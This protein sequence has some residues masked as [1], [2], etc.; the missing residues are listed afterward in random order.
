VSN[1][2]YPVPARKKFLK[3]KLTEYRLILDLLSQ[4]TLAFP[5]IRFT[6]THN[7]KLVFDFPKTQD[8]TYRMNQVL[9]DSVVSHMIPVSFSD[10]YLQ[11][12]G[13]ITTPQITTKSS[14][15]Q[16]LFIN[17]RLISDRLISL[18]IKEAYANMLEQSAYPISVLFLS[19]PFE[20]VDVNVHPRKEQV[21]F[22]NN[23]VIYDGV[24]EAIHTTLQKE[25]IT[26]HAVPWKNELHRESEK[27]KITLSLGGKTLKRASKNWSIQNLGLISTNTDI[28]QAHKTYLI[29]STESGIMLIDQHA[30]HERILYAEF[31]KEFFSESK[32]KKPF[33]LSEPILFSFTPTE[34]AIVTEYLPALREWGFEFEPFMDNT[35][36]LRGVPPFF[37][38]RNYQKLIDEV[39][40]TVI[41]SESIKSIDSLSNKMITYLSCRAAVKAGDTLSVKQRKMIIETLEKIMLP[42]PMADRQK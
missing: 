14:Q 37:Q 9:G 1:L 11:I 4:Y 35:F 18:T 41:S 29:T 15:K 17:N 12:S 22:F 5:Q 10:T 30:A 36:T 13:F 7:G 39:I 20:T 31:K 26:F 32:K 8:I 24:K 21:S 16:S 3:S 42:V 25:N 19:L 2:F 40:D 33:I 28:A 34:T 38:D 27:N 23:Q 6:L